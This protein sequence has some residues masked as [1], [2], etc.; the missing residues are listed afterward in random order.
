[1]ECMVR[2]RVR[3]VRWC[4]L[5]ET[6]LSGAGCKER[7][8][9]AVV[10]CMGLYK[11]RLVRW[12]ALTKMFFRVRGARCG[13][14]SVVGAWCDIGCGGYAGVHFVQRCNG[15]VLLELILHRNLHNLTF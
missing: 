3:W 7:V 8:Q 5:T 6:A 12:C 4:A 11:V 14:S 1:M 10:G 9:N 2:Y 13:C 15:D